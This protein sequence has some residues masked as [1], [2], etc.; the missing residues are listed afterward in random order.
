MRQV[1]NLFK[2]PAL[3]VDTANKLENAVSFGTF[4]EIG[5]LA[6][7]EVFRSSRSGDL[8]GRMTRTVLTQDGKITSYQ[9][10]PTARFAPVVIKILS[11][12]R[13]NA[14]KKTLAN[15]QFPNLNGFSY[16]TSATVAD[17][18]TTTYQSQSAAV[19]LI[20]LEKQSLPTSLQQS[21][22]SWESLVT[23]AK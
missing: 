16:L 23:P 14:F 6:E 19:Q 10:S 1:S 2:A 15:Q 13:L 3:L 11:P 17:Y 8:T 12:A 22:A 7:N 18:P 9:S 5:S 4:G 21:I 20:D